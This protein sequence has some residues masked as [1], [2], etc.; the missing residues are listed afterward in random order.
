M[1]RIMSEFDPEATRRVGALFDVVSE[2][3]DDVGVPFFQP[4]AASLLGAMP[5]RPGERW[6]DVGCGRGAVLLQVAAAVR[7][8]TV[9]G[10][11]ISTGMLERC[12][13]VMAAAGLDNVELVIDDAQTPAVGGGPYDTLSS[14]LVLFFLPDP[15]TALRR[16]LRLVVPGGRIGV[17]TFGE[18]DPRWVALW[19]VFTPYLP[20]HVLDA[21]TTGTSGPFASDVG[22]E[23]L[24]NET[25]WTDTHTVPGQVDVRFETPEQWQRFS[26]ATGER[27]LWMSVPEA[28][29]DTV[30]DRAYALLAQDADADGS[31]TYWQRIRHTLARRPGDAS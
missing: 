7:P 19:Q 30:R 5:P 9:V 13:Q 22:M 16:W 17:T 2:S 6:L 1:L 3:Y 4:I 12:R 29:R 26:M 18:I 20:Q 14:N 25:G 28:E 31:V 11:D 21:R 10:T 23:Q 8:A 24:L 15:A 27:S